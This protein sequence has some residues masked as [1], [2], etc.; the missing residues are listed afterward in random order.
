[1]NS[2]TPTMGIGVEYD[3]TTTAS[4]GDRYT[5]QIKNVDFGIIERAKQDIAI[6]KKVRTLKITLANGQV[7]SNARIED[8]GKLTGSTSNVTYMKPSETTNPANG[9]VRVEL[10]N[11][12][13]QGAT[14]EVGYEF[15]VSNN[16]E[17]DYLS[18]NFYKYGI[19]EGDVIT[20]RATGIIDYLDKEWS[21]INENNP[22]WQVKTLDDVKA[23]LTEDVYQ[24]E[25]STIND[26]II[27]Y[28]DV[29]KDKPIEPTKSES[30]MLK[31]SK[32]LTTSDDIS[33][34]NETEIVE[35]DK[36]G[37]SD[38]ESTPGNYVPGNGHTET[39]DHMA[40]TV[41]VTP[42][43]GGSLSNIVIVMIG[44]VALLAIAGGIIIIKK[45][46]LGDNTEDK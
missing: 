9:F 15:I 27:L 3:T 6:T 30:V 26:K 36:T 18:E 1:M 2:T 8:D 22:E 21:F 4:T 16:S 42:P 35:V 20:I 19:I 5:Y 29:L 32:I 45:K 11:E 17:L 23:L 40:E 7:V 12:M 10:D 43:T 37:G 46:A 14:L 39:D 25:T 24:N 34:D 31:V 28:T 33:L 13:I 38:L 44:I 41:I